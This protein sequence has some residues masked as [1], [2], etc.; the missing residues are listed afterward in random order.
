[1]AQPRSVFLNLI[2]VRHLIEQEVTNL[3]YGTLL[4]HAF[5]AKSGDRTDFC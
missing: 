3:M 5:Q 1:M 2:F 4:D